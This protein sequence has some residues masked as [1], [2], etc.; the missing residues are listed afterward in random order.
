MTLRTAGHARARDARNSL[1]LA[2]CGRSVHHTAGAR[3][4][5][6]A[7]AAGLAVDDDILSR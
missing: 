6:R 1:G 7:G 3:L 5:A 4:A 2:S